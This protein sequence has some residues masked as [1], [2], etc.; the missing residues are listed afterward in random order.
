MPTIK[1]LDTEFVTQADANGAFRI[2][3]VPAGDY[4]LKITAPEYFD[5][6]ILHTK[7]QVEMATEINYGLTK[8][9]KKAE[10]R[11]ISLYADEVQEIKRLTGIL[12]GKIVDQ[13]GNPLP[14]VEV[15][16]QN[17][18][19][20]GNIERLRKNS[21]LQILT[22]V[23]IALKSPRKGYPREKSCQMSK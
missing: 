2:D 12:K 18:R 3:S 8:A 21:L 14:D 23:Y 4:T 22:R 19:K 20:N 10:P 16:I 5:I 1:L 9:S 15:S 11:L 7:I 17:T 6:A 13:D